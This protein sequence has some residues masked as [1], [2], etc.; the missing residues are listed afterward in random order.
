[1]VNYGE[2]LTHKK[3][4]AVVIMAGAKKQCCICFSQRKDEVQHIKAALVDAMTTSKMPQ[5][6]T[7]NLVSQSCKAGSFLQKLGKS[8]YKTKTYKFMITLNLT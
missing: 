5:K 4:P 3:I 6:S 2:A 8:Q 7:Q 1:M